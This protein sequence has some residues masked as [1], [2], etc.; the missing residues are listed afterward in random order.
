MTTLTAAESIPAD[1]ITEVL[2]L[3][4]AVSSTLDNLVSMM[5]TGGPVVWLLLCFSLV[6]LTVFL[7]KVGQLFSLR[8]R[9]GKSVD[10]AYAYLAEGQSVE[11][12]TLVNA[13]KN[14]RAQVLSHALHMISTNK[15]SVTEIRDE[16]MRRS[17]LCLGKLESH[18]R[19]LEVIAMLA[20]LLGL[21]GTVLGMIEAFRAMESAGAQ[22]NPAILSGGIWQ[23][24]LTTAVGLAV[25]IPVS[26][27]HSWLERKVEVQ[28]ASLQNDIDVLSAL[29]QQKTNEQH[30]VA[31]LQRTA[32]AVS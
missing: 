2:P 26:I 19:I 7:V 24:L 18:L 22:V 17:R 10:R 25:A 20:P 14:P 29:V 30:Q 9:P 27:A 8:Q 1:V 4:T 28:A 13:Q 16:A 6:A 12:N 31:R 32:R 3:E 11:A 5:I 15:Y 23:A 21:F